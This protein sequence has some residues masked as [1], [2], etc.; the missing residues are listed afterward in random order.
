M[1][2]KPFRN[3]CKSQK[4]RRLRQMC[5]PIC[6]LKEKIN[7]VLLANSSAEENYMII[8]TDYKDERHIRQDSTNGIKIEPE[9]NHDHENE[10]IHQVTPN[11]METE[12]KIINSTLIQE[13]DTRKHKL[14]VKKEL[15]Q[16]VCQYNISHQATGA[17]LKI[18]KNVQNISELHDLPFDSRTLLHTPKNVILRDVL[19]G[20]Y[21]HDGLKN[22]L[23]DQLRALNANKIS[24]DIKINI[25]IDGLPLAKSSRSQLYPI[26]GQI[27]PIVAEPFV[28]G[29]YH[30]YNKP[31]CPNIFFQD[32]IKEYKT[33]HEEGFQFDNNLHFKV[34][35]RAVICDIP[36][37]SFV[38]CIKGFNGY[39]GCSKCMQEGKYICH[40]MIFPDLNAELRTDAN[41][42]ERANDDHHTAT[43][44]FEEIKLGMV[45]QFPLDYMHLVCL[46]VI[47]KCY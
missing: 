32:F 10:C 2:R 36:A 42:I 33:L 26:L 22:A 45:S 5:N 43:S 31:N 47:K 20:Q 38:T 15:M 13:S 8:E 46:G 40:R 39:F 9:I 23:I 11:K 27:Y 44:I 28:V 17:L 24:H 25:N 16:W 3:L 35:I 41:F 6:N 29:A 18:L 1:E 4:N 12:S 30:G 21:L 37:R 34:T 19:P 14:S 7:K